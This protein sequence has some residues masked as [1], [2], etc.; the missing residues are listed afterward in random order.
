MLPKH[1]H[2]TVSSITYPVSTWDFLR[3]LFAIHVASAWANGETAFVRM[4]VS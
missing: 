1:E 3:S 4:E 2:K